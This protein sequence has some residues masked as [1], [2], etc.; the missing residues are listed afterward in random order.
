MSVR[1]VLRLMS[2]AQYV[3]VHEL[4][5]EFGTNPGREPD[6]L[7]K[8]GVRGDAIVEVFGPEAIGLRCLVTFIES[9]AVARFTIDMASAEWRRLR[10]LSRREAVRLLPLALD[11]IP[12]TRVPDVSNFD[13]QAGG[14][15]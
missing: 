15:A 8:S 6:W 9:G 13:L 1:P 11:R 14:Q 5:R 7:R 2:F 3:R 10:K 12:Y 4:A